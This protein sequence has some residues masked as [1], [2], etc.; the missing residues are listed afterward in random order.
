MHGYTGEPSRSH[1]IVALGAMALKK[2]FAPVG[3]V[4][5]VVPFK[6]PFLT[7]G[8]PRF[9]LLRGLMLTDKDFDGLSVRVF[10]PSEPSGKVVVAIHGGSYVGE[11]TIFHWWTYTDMARQ[12]GATVVVPGYTLSP[13]GTASTEVPRMAD[14]LT[15]AID[16]RGAENV[17]VFGDSAGGGLALLAVQELVRR[18]AT[19]PG[20]L[21]LLAPW[22][23]VSMSDARS[24]N[25]DDPLLDV[26]HS[27]RYGKS[28]AG[29]VDTRDPLV[30]PLFGSLDSLPPTVVYSSSRDLLTIDA[31]RLRERVL[32]EGNSQ[33][34]FRLR[35]GLL[36]DY[37]IYVP[38]PEA[39][40]E[41][42]NLYRDLNL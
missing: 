34:T 22:L 13:D 21:V 36:H 15:A 8:V 23:D 33:V 38:L 5:A 4:L 40:A 31:A 37:P 20:R 39:R 41:R 2:V 12:T 17:S 18:D 3:G 14:F 16:E 30:S 28:W 11:A 26:A 1:Q 27:V 19:T 25:V 7:D 10:T 9:F 42:P 6:I 29:N 32:A 24:G 35:Q